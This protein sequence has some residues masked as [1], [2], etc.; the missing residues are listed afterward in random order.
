M[1]EDK[2]L[3]DRIRRR[4]HDLNEEMQLAVDAGLVVG[5]SVANG[6]TATALWDGCK[7]KRAAPSITAEIVRPL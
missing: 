7:V 3:A 1:A 5:V 6:M 4:V 2:E